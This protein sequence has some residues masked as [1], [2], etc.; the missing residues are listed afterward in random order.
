[1]NSSVTKICKKCG[2]EKSKEFFNKKP[3]GKNGLNARCKHCIGDYEQQYRKNN[4]EK[5]KK[6]RKKYKEENRESIKV[7]DRAYRQTEKGKENASIRS[8]RWRKINPEK[9]KARDKKER[10]RTPKERRNLQLIY[11]FG[12]TLDEYN[13]LLNSQKG[14][15]AICIGPE[16]IFDKRANKTRDLAV[17]H[18]HKTGKVRGL[19]CGACNKALG[20]FRDKVSIIE[21]ASQYL[22]LRGNK[23]GDQNVKVANTVQE[24]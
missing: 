12:I 7:K 11:R 1:M 19:L 21:N 4:H 22:K 13:F 17:D 14:V 5:E 2:L 15:C 9:A 24:K 8:I 16:T 18:D 6:R 3:G 23:I 10:L 20:L